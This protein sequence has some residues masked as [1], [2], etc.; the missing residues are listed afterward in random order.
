MRT[1]NPQVHSRPKIEARGRRLSL[2]ICRMR[3][4]YLRQGGTVDDRLEAFLT[5]LTTENIIRKLARQDS[6]ALE[7][8]VSACLSAAMQNVYADVSLEKAFARMTIR[9]FLRFEKDYFERAALR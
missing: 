3:D 4:E 6:A 1:G 9:D 5:S 8:L 7:E 2:A